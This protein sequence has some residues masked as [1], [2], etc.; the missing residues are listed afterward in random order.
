MWSETYRPTKISKL[1]GNE[2]E[3]SEVYEW[4]KSWKKGVKPVLLLGPPGSGKTTLA[5]ILAQTLGYSLVELN[6][7]DVRTKKMLDNHIGPLERHT[8]LYPETFLVFFDEVDGIYGRADFGGVD[9]ILDFIEKV[10][11][12]VIMAANS[13]EAS[14]VLRLAKKSKVVTL[15]PLSYRD[16]EMYL[17]DILEREDASVSP[18]TLEQVIRQ[19]RGDLRAAINSLQG[20]ADAKPT[21]IFQ[22][23][24]EMSLKETITSLYTANTREEALMVLK[25]CTENNTKEKIRST[26]N[27]VVSAQLDDEE[28]ASV[29]PKL[30]EL[31]MLSYQTEL[32]GQ[33]QLRKYFDILLVDAIFN[34]RKKLAF[35]EY[36]DISWP[37]LQKIYHKEP[38]LRKTLCQ[39][40]AKQ[41]FASSNKVAIFYYPYLHLFYQ[42]DKERSKRALQLDDRETMF[43]SKP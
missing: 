2:R 43:L 5:R 29:L 26:H 9:F 4:L 11:Y 38:D 24:K 34:T 36:A 14:T 13:E 35:K 18:G 20:L 16:V 1:V 8:S 22:R 23:D 12:P 19:T 31:D 27:S 42:K 41:V 28:R 32:R 7:S 37:V 40:V 3:H 15:K 30:S 39:K 10:N 25:R 33:Y 21:T 17:K 6:A